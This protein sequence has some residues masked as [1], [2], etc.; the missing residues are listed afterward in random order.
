MVKIAYKND[1]EIDNDFS[2]PILN[3]F[4][5]LALADENYEF[6]EKIKKAIE[7]KQQVEN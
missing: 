3:E 7:A 6:A 1:K 2:K 5:S 4:L